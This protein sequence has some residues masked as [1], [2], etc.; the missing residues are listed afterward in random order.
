LL[1]GALMSVAFN[2]HAVPLDP[3]LTMIVA[4]RSFR[5]AAT[6]VRR[7]FGGVTE[8]TGFVLRI[9]NNESAMR[10][11]YFSVALFAD[12]DNHII[13]ETIPRH[14]AHVAAGQT[15][16]VE[17]ELVRRAD[18]ANAYLV[19]FVVS[20]GGE[21]P[22]AH[23]R[24]DFPL[25]LAAEPQGSREL[26]VGDDLFVV[27]VGA[28]LFLVSVMLGTVL[29]F[30][31]ELNSFLSWLGGIV[32][33]LGLYGLAGKPL[34]RNVLSGVL[35][36]LWGIFAFQEWGGLEAIGFTAL[37]WVV[38]RSLRAPNRLLRRKIGAYWA[39]LWQK[40]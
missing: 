36:L 9:T 30:H 6:G 17:V 16:E 27:L 23:Y 3:R 12:H 33:F 14:V 37:A 13:N 4:R 34:I 10:S 29:H 31:Y 35:S 8:N 22:L 19:D 7:G 32:C 38:H 20:D 26:E 1:S 24:P 2:L 5:H 15:V 21:T 11:Y 28:E 18:F 25:A 39:Q 40:N